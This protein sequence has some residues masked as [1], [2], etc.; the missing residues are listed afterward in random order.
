MTPRPQRM[1]P[2]FCKVAAEI[3]TPERCGCRASC[4]LGSVQKLVVD[5]QSDSRLC[6]AVGVNLSRLFHITALDRMFPMFANMA[7][8][9]EYASLLG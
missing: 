5:Q 8:A 4:A 3:V 9:R 7:S 2:A 1:N 6:V